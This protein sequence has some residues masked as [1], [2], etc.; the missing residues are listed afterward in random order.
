MEDYVL[1]IGTLQAENTALKVTVAQLQAMIEELQARL[2]Q[3][4]TNSSKPPASDG[5]QKKTIKPALTREKGRKPGGQKGHPGT[6]L[7]LV[8]TPDAVIDHEL[9]TCQH[10]GKDLTNTPPTLHQRRQVFDLPPPALYVEEHR[11]MARQCACGCVNLGQFPDSVSAPVQYGPR[12]Q[13]Q[14]VLLNIDYKLPFAKIR[15]FWADQTGYGY[16]PATLVQAQTT[17]AHQLV[18]IRAHIGQQIQQAPVVHFDETG[19][20]VGGKLHRTGGPVAPRSLHRLMDLSVCSS[21]PG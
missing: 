14:S 15:Q 12:I 3:N 9:T 4:S 16:N 5:F 19:L 21:Q 13:A 1:I 18:P 2:A 17:L 10:C 6:T 8:Q 7:H 20:R 11:Q